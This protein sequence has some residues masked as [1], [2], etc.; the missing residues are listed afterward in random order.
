MDGLASMESIADIGFLN[1]LSCFVDLIK[2]SQ[3]I[4]FT[5]PRANAKLQN[6]RDKTVDSS[7]IRNVAK[8]TA[9]KSA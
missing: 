4:K 6:L 5:V 2:E 1:S 7:I 9:Q 3:N 8:T